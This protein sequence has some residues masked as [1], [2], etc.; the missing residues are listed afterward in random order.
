M[1]AFLDAL[2]TRGLTRAVLTRNSRA[3]TLPMLA[4]LGLQFDPVVC[5][6]DAPPKP[7]P[8]AIWQI[9]EAWGIQ[10]SECVL[11]GDFRFD[12][13]AARRAGAYAVLFSGGGA[14]MQTDDLA[15]DLVLSTFVEPEEFWAWLGQIDLGG[16]GRCC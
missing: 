12:I 4:R 1:H 5:R 3:T 6:E 8:A 7:D 2:A 10:P 14:S 13:E 9:C 16:R 15:A 11:V